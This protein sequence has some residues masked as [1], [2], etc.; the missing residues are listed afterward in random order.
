[1]SKILEAKARVC[2]CGPMGLEAP[3]DKVFTVALPNVFSLTFP[4]FEAPL[5]KWSRGDWG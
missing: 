3:R 5:A 1:M 4:G 2:Y